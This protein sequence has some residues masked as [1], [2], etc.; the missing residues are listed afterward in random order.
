MDHDRKDDHELLRKG[1]FV[2][3]EMKRL[4]KLRK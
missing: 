3:V 2:E 1:G 4:S